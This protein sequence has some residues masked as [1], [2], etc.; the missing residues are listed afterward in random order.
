[1]IAYVEAA[2]KHVGIGEWSLSFMELSA[3]LEYLRLEH[4]Q[5]PDLCY[6]KFSSSSPPCH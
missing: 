4:T 6:Q 2:N 1:M 3:E 5:S